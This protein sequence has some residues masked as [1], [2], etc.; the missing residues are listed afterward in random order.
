MSPVALV[1]MVLSVSVFSESTA[2]KTPV[3]KIMDSISKRIKR[4]PVIDLRILFFILFPFSGSIWVVVKSTH[5]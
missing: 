1:S 2:A 3:E 4:R 5:L